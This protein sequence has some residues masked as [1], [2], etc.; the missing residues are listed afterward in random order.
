MHFYVYRRNKNNKP[1]ISHNTPLE[2]E[3]EVVSRK[4][5]CVIVEGGGAGAGSREPA[6]METGSLQE[7]IKERETGYQRGGAGKQEK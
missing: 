3:L 6:S 2:R 1:S 5:E 7:T 4:C